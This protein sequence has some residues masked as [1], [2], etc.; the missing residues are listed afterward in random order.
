MRSTGHGLDSTWS[1][2][3]FDSLQSRCHL[4]AHHQP[5]FKPFKDGGF[6]A[7]SLCLL[8]RE[9]DGPGRASVTLQGAGPP[10][11]PTQARGQGH[12]QD[13][14]FGFLTPVAGMEHA[15][16]PLR[17]QYQPILLECRIRLG[18]CSTPGLQKFGGPA[19][20][21]V[22]VDTRRQCTPDDVQ[23]RTTCQY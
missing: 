7:S 6:R 1:H 4:R 12:D 22:H 13:P 23:A 17:L 9:I 2:N 10:A 16:L 14:R 8:R 11:L 15:T 5:P 20:A 21:H 18:H 19:G 3:V